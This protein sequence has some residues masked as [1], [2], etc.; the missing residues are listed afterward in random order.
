MRTLRQIRL[1]IE[2]IFVNIANYAYGPAEGET[3]ARCEVLSDPLR[4]V[5][6]FLDGV[7]YSYEDGKNVLTIMKKL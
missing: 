1:A 3:E 7:Q 5:V 4:V 6:Q 2:E